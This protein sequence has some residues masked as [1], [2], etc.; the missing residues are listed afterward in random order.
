[1]AGEWLKFDSSLPEKP[2]TMAITAAMGWEDT[3]LAVGKLM[4]LF[5]WFD[6]H[7]TDG[8]ARGVTPALLDRVIGATGFCAAVANAG[9]LVV[10]EGGLA[11]RSFD[12]HNGATAK[13]RAATAKRVA[14][15][16]ENIGS[17][18]A[19][20]AATVTPAL[21]REEK[22]REEEAKAKAGVSDADTA[23]SADPVCAVVVACYHLA[24]PNCQRTEVLT[25][26]RRRRILFADKLARQLSREQGWEWDREWFWSAYFGECQADP[27][28]RGDV[29]NPKNPRWRQ[30]LDVLIAEDRF[31][32]IMD[33]AVAANRE[34]A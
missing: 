13:S 9:W 22:R 11:L 34:T 28:L 8:N 4:R 7:T 31:A 27:W 19:C 29:P 16:R 24:L 6:Q 23:P 15:H 18:V 1:M 2:E 10:I 12:K 30:N 20:N 17:N 25:P 21:A 33:A 14:Q 26:K 3:D 32:G 5:R